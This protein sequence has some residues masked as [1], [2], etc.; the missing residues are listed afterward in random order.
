MKPVGNFKNISKKKYKII[1]VKRRVN[2]I[3]DK[4]V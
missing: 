1:L 4:E 3:L 2:K